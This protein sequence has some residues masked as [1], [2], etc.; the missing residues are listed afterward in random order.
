[1][2]T[3]VAGRYDTFEE[4]ENAS[5]HLRSIGLPRE[6]VSVFFNNPPGQHDLVEVNA[7]QDAD[8]QSTRADESALAGAAAGAMIGLAALAAGPLAAGAGIGIGAYVGS[9]AGAVNG[10]DNPSKASHPLRRPSGVMLAA[11]VGGTMLEAVA[12]AAMRQTGALH[13]ETA[14]GRWAGGDWADFDPLVEPRL[15]DEPEPML[16]AQR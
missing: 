6:A 10:T 13:I 5:A 15:V 1:M 7:G 16:A 2:G 3:I 4:A 11:H 12:I 8:P 9:L 14:D